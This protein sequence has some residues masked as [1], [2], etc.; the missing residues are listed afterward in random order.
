MRYTQGLFQGLALRAPT[1]IFTP[2]APAEIV[3]ICPL[4]GSNLAASG[5]AALPLPAW[6]NC[7][8]PELQVDCRMTMFGFT[9]VCS[10]PNE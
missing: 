5:F 9:S 3:K 2:L 4:R 6:S 7:S 10:P 1:S 8:V